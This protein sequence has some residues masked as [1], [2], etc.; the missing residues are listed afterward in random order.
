MKS[1][2]L[3]LVLGCAAATTAVAGENL[4]W[5][6]AFQSGAEKG[7]P[8]AS[9]QS[10]GDSKY[11][12]QELTLD[13]GRE[14]RRCVRLR[15]TRFEQ[16]NAACH[17]MICQMGVPVRQ[18]KTY[19]VAFW[20]R[21]EDIRGETVSV[22]LSDTSAWS[23]CGLQGMFVPGPEWSRHE[24]AFR[25]TH[26]CTMTRF[27]IWFNST[28]SLWLDEVLFEE[29]RGPLRR[30]G[31]AVPA[32]G[33]KNLIP[34]AGF[35]CGDD[36][37][38]SAEWDNAVHWG[39]R[40]NRLF[41]QIA[42]TGSSEGRRCLRIDLSP[43]NMP[44]SYFDYYEL[45]R[46]PI[47]A[48]LAANR[49]YLEVQPGK[50]Y[51]FSAY[52]RAEAGRDH[53]GDDANVR[54]PGRL[55]VREFDAGSFEKPI[56]ISDRWQ[57]YAMPFTPRSKWCYV[58]AG[59]DLRKTAAN[60]RPPER[61]TC[62]LDALQLEAGDA[63]TEFEPRQPVEFGMSTGRVG[64]V[65]AWGDR[66]DIQLTVAKRDATLPKPAFDLAMT[67]FF[68]RSVWR[69]RAQV[70]GSRTFS[71]RLGP[72]QLRGFFRLNVKMTCGESSA[73]KTMRLAV[74]PPQSGD[75]S[76]FGV[77]HA[78]PWPHLLD[79][80]RKAGLVWCRDWSLKWQ[81]VEPEKGRFT[82]E[83][84][85]YQI[86][87][88]LAHHLRVLGLLPFP[89]S[90][91]SSTAPAGVTGKGGYPQIRGRVAYAPRDPAEFENYVAATV[92]HYKDRI[93]WWQ[94]FNE[95]LYT[96][97]ALPR[98]HGYDG[99]VYARLVRSFAHA[100]RKADPGCHILA[101]IG[102]LNDGQIMED[103]ERFFVAGG[104]AAVDAVDI[105]HYPGM[106][107]PEFIEGLAEKLGSLMDKHGNRKPIWLT[108]YGYYA[109]DEPWAIPATYEGF[110]SPLP[111][112][113]TQAEYAVRWATILLANGVDK[114]FY[115]AGTCGEINRANLEGVFYQYGG[116]PQKIYAAQA[117]MAH[118][119]TPNCRPVKRLPLAGTAR[120]Y[121]FRD[122]EA[123]I[124]ILWDPSRGRAEAA[125]EL[126]DARLKIW[127]VVGRPQSTHHVALSGAPV[128]VLGCGQSDAEFEAALRAGVR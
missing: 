27:Q 40:M 42:E 67:D 104:L 4:L 32:G 54:I 65:L 91:W 69:E 30:P 7:G 102:G 121:L 39:G 78:Y 79:L 93:G 70:E 44:V 98:Q 84:T 111:S 94:C 120:G 101:G 108:E 77:N 86:D 106:R 113:Q 72:K 127:D 26:D 37:W 10:A 29:T 71:P 109:N 66:L 52:L 92:T 62:W 107:S 116:E 8:P 11:V 22:A 17:A 126:S 18:G 14:G 85:D 36:G 89:S 110:D 1:H 114:I 12:T 112:E 19:R 58:L 115:H 35:E 124:G 3:T 117:V 128:Y 33:H 41:G 97:Y 38:G 90:N 21:G 59:P 57:R 15:C 119:L 99:A 75:D 74:I 68:G 96:D 64:N 51:V 13:T 48:P 61:V 28:G 118:L 2:W 47:K 76:R 125:I 49:G 80:S 53:D 100:A 56:E 45:S 20:A 9:W 60:P 5:N 16:A 6:P 105:H 63:A 46:L 23:N 95:P 43:E 31:N 123:T 73:E 24:M 81:E 87:R 82:F 103:F 122:G 50:R 34:N 55:A 88:P 83:Q 25:A